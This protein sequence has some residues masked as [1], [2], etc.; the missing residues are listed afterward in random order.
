MIIKVTYLKYKTQ[1]PLQSTELNTTKAE[2]ILCSFDLVQF[3]FEMLRGFFF[4]N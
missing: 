1:G 4:S 3:R 2:M